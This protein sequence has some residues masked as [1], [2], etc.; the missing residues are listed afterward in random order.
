MTLCFVWHVLTKVIHHPTSNIKRHRH[1]EDE[2]V[3]L[4]SLASTTGIS[5]TRAVL[6]EQVE[7]LN[8]NLQSKVDA[9]TAELQVK[10]K[11]LQEARNK[12]ND[13][14]T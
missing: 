8:R 3:F 12:E 14:I 5:L 11:E 13:M 4:E 2:I 1:A 10:V 7:E 6:Y 9:Q